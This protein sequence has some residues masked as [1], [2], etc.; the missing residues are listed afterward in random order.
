M[1]KQFFMVK[2]SF[3]AYI[4]AYFGLKTTM[5]NAHKRIQAQKNELFQDRFKSC[6]DIAKRKI[7]AR[8]FQIFR[9]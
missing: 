8:G 7:S 9:N 5:T 1:K 3:G 2:T 6:F 4:K